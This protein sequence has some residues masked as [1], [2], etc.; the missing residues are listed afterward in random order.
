MEPKRA[1][2]EG[3]RCI[4]VQP[5]IPV[6]PSRTLMEVFSGYGDP[7]QYGAAL[8]PTLPRSS[9]PV[10][11]ELKESGGMCIKHFPTIKKKFTL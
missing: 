6:P 7:S 11:S 3:N 9:I 5:K 2:L 8:S 10:R 1:S 4:A